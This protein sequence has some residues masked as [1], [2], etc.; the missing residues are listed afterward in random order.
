[1][2]AHIKH[3]QGH[4][5]KIAGSN[6]DARAQALQ[7]NSAWVPQWPLLVKSTQCYTG[8]SSSHLGGL[9]V[10]QP[11][12]CRGLPVVHQHQLCLQVQNVH[13]ALTKSTSLSP[14]A[15]ITLQLFSLFG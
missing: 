15:C 6:L 11:H 8:A 4:M 3:N 12:R 9:S 5:P 10:H 13:G 14:L 2:L 7:Q 1:M